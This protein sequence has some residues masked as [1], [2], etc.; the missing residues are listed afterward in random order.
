MKKDWISVET[1]ELFRQKSLARQVNDSVMGK[2]LGKMIRQSLKKDRMIRLNTTAKIAE[3]CL[4]Q[5]NVREA[6]NTIKYWYKEIAQ[7]TT[8]STVEDINKVSDEFQE[9]YRRKNIIQPEIPTYVNF[10]VD[11]N[12]PNED[13]IV[14]ALKKL[15]NRRAPGASGISV[16]DL[17]KWYRKARLEEQKDETA[18]KIWENVIKII[19]NAFQEGNVPTAFTQGTLVLIPKP[20]TSS[21]RGIALL[22]TIYKL[23]SMIIHRRLISSINFHD[24]IHGFRV[25]RGTSTAIINLKLRMQLARRKKDP[26][27]LIFLDVKKAYD[28]LDRDR[29]ISLLRKYGVGEKICILLINMWKEDTIVPKQQQFYGKAFKAE[30]GVRQGDIVS[31]TIFN[32]VI[33][34]IIRNAY[35]MLESLGD[36]DIIVQFYADDGIIGGKDYDR[37]QMIMDKITNDLLSFGLVMNIAKT[38]AMAMQVLQRRKNMSTIAYERKITKQGLSAKERDKIYQQCQWCAKTVMTKSLKKH[39]LSKYCQRAQKDNRIIRHDSDNIANNGNNNNNRHDQETT[40]PVNNND[41]NDMIRRYNNRDLN[42]NNINNNGIRRYDNTIIQESAIIRHDNNN[43]EKEINSQDITVVVANNSRDNMIRRYDNREVENNNNDDDNNSNNDDNNEDNDDNNNND[44]DG[45]I[46]Q[47]DMQDKVIIKCPCFKCPFTTNNRTGMRKHFR[48]RHPDAIIIIQ[49]E[50]LL[51]R[52][53]ECGLFQ[54]NVN[55]ARHLQSEECKKYA[56]IKNN[57]RFDLCQKSADNVKFTVSGEEIKMVSEFKYLGR[58]L[59]NNDMDLKAVES[60]L[61]KARRVWGMIGKIVKKKSHCNPRIMSIFYKV[62]VQTVLLYG[63][64]SWVM[65]TLARNKVNS[66]HNR[67]SRFITGRHITLDGETWIYPSR[68][69]TLQEADLLG[70]E[71]YITKRKETIG[72]YA[73]TSKILESCQFWEGLTRNNKELMWWRQSLSK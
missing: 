36:D 23:I 43:G 22:E 63:S 71:E 7:K 67:C 51:P 26:L 35:K 19:K 15:K 10:T 70:I 28:S 66:F 1:H 56:N 27:Y 45:G 38:E 49:Q 57:R 34:A 39:Y 29:T 13:E 47:I 8:N 14:K 41:N 55:S 46:F 24:G 52:C 25:G 59:T 50:G 3:N 64:E 44:D 17:K 62:I 60:Q 48:A 32:I 33:D 72:P 11:D 53:Q 65:S 2:Q 42:D 16:E 69:S 30:R 40:A 4:R 61:V 58:I 18:V 5:K 37:V 73:A 9:L 68:A 54:G 21:F 20:G 12:I 31:P 6:Y